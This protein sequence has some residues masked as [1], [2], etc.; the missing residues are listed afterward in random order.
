MR[1]KD[2]NRLL[3]VKLIWHELKWGVHSVKFFSQYSCF[4]YHQISCDFHTLRDWMRSV[5]YY[6]AIFGTI[7]ENP[8]SQTG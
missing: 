6:V 4:I 5:N 7:L 3:L 8:N 1:T 2:I